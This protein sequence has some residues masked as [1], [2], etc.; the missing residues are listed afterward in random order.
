MA[1]F[2]FVSV[3]VVVCV[4]AVTVYAVRHLVRVKGQGLVLLGLGRWRA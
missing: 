2:N 1:E 4:A 3:I